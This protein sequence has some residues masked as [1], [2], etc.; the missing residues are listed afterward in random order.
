MRNSF[1][2]IIFILTTLIFISLK[3]ACAQNSRFEKKKIYNLS[4]LTIGYGFQGDVEPNQIAFTGIT[5]MAGYS[6][7]SAGGLGIGSG[8]LAYNGSY[9]IPL[10]LE[11]GYYFREFG[12]GKMRFFA[13]ADAGALFRLNGDIPPTRFFANPL[14]GMLIP[15][16]RHKEVS[17]SLGFFTQWNPNYEDY[18][19]QNEFDYFFN[20]KLGLRFF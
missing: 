11:G 9:S 20:A 2:I 4:E 17:I 10:Y 14:G 7:S 12:L 16:A 1:I 8:I 15:V 3:D 18:P 19:E 6:F 5:S 13:K